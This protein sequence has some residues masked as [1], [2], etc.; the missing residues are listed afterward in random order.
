MKT[1]MEILKRTLTQLLLYYTRYLAPPPLPLISLPSPSPP[2]L[3]GRFLDAVKK[4][5][6][7]S[8]TL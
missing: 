7:E 6:A 2:P 8:G 3:P 5:C 4:Y 1:G